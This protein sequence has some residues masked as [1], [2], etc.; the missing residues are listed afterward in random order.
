MADHVEEKSIDPSTVFLPPNRETRVNGGNVRN[1]EANPV[2]IP[3]K[4]DMCQ[5]GC[6]L[7]TFPIFVCWTFDNLNL[8]RSW[9]GYVVF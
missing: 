5:F 3:A 7:K 4:K 1:G 2:P 6:V 8:Q 9:V